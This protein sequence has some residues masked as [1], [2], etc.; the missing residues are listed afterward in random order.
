MALGQQAK[1]LETLSR[2]IMVE[3]LFQP[4]KLQLPC[5]MKLTWMPSKNDAFHCCQQMYYSP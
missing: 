5:V 3:S 1:W 4:E 2:S